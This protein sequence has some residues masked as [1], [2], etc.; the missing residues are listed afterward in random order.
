MLVLEHRLSGA[1]TGEPVSEA[2]ADEVNKHAG[3]AAGR[4]GNFRMG[5]V[6]RKVDSGL[7]R[8]K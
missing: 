8:K 7:M 3:W 1:V 4:G 6:I 2:A 5:R